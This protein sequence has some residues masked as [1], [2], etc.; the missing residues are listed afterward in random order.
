MNKPIGNIYLGRRFTAE[1]I[2]MF[3]A[4]KLT[5]LLNEAKD[6]YHYPTQEEIYNSLFDN[7]K[8]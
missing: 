2:E 1:E 7:S 6:K 8:E 3:Q 4:G 5:H